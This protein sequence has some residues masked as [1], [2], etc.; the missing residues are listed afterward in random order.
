MLN[1]SRQTVQLVGVALSLMVWW[2]VVLVGEPIPAG[3]HVARRGVVAPS[4][5]ARS[6]S[7]LSSLVLGA[8]R[9]LAG[10]P[11]TVAS[12][13]KRRAGLVL[14][15]GVTAAGGFRVDLDDRFTTRL[16]LRRRA[17][18]ENLTECSTRAGGVEASRR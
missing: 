14:K 4:R 17:S 16:I 12:V 15:P 6:A 2:P 5:S 1:R 8:P 10:S 11:S 3:R 9:S 13:R 7:G 18:G